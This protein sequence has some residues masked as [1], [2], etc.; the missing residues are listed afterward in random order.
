VR[1]KRLYVNKP[2][3]STSDVLEIVTDESA[4]ARSSRFEAPEIRLRACGSQQ[5]VRSDFRD[6]VAWLEGAYGLVSW[7]KRNDVPAWARNLDLVLTLH[8]QHWTGFVFNTFDEMAEIL[9]DITADVP[10]N[11][12]LAY[13]PGW[14]GRYYWQ[15]PDY[16]PGK[17]LG[18]DDGFARLAATARSL[19]VHLMPMFGANGANVRRYP[20][21][22]RAALRSPSNT[23]PALINEPDWDNDRAPEDDLVFLNPG[24][25]QFRQHLVQRIADLVERHPIDGVFLDT[26]GCWFNDPRFEMYPGYKELVGEIHHRHPDLLVCGEGWYDALLGVF[27]VNQTWLDVSQPQRFDD[28]PIAYARTL[29]HLN[30]GAPG[31]GSTGVHEGGT[32]SLGKPLRVPGHIPALSVVDDTFT[33]HRQAVRD[34]CRAV[35]GERL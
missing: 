27:P 16:R 33:K 2:H 31:A 18:G 8:G 6:H 29:G 24:A 11:R 30:E 26:S 32:R 20:D 15:Y 3:W 7:E 4:V 1:P 12:I 14:D 19:G 22:E 28:L 10:G 35:V 17:D 23:Y 34:F 5:E 9:K 13:L 21:W 25:P